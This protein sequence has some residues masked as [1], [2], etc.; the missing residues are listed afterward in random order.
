M[1]NHST[2]APQ[3]SG[4]R[5]AAAAVATFLPMTFVIVVVNFWIYH[6]RDRFIE[7]HPEW[8]AE[9]GAP[10][11]SRSIADPAIG[12]P[13]AFWMSLCAAM[14]L[15]GCLPICRLY[16]LAG[17]S[18]PHTGKSTRRL[19]IWFVPAAMALEVSTAVGMVMLSEYRFPDNNFLH[20]VGSYVF[21][22]SQAVVILMIGIVSWRITTDSA[23]VAFLQERPYINPR[24]TRFRGPFA[25]GG[26]FLAL[27]F[28]A[29]FFLKDVD[30]AYGNDLV[31]NVYVLSEPSLISYFLAVLATYY[32][33][34]Y[35][36]LRRSPSAPGRLVAASQTPD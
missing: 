16:W 22:V 31:H 30:F 17:R 19:L 13:F 8:I 33:E 18:M 21:F 34:L 23:A 10:T 7:L 36:T 24:L 20:M 35:A 26:V 28:L 2:S 14:L 6:A 12:E 5:F 11:I 3:Q 27:A 29:L 15:L 9:H 25:F 1:T 4:W 32:V